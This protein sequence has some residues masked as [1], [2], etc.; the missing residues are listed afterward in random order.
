M[1]RKDYFSQQSSAYATFRPTYPDALYRFIFRHLKQKVCAWDCATGNGQVA[2]YLARHFQSVYATDISQQQINHASQTPNIVYS[3]SPAE[4]TVFDDRKFD[5]ITVAQALHWFDVSA[6]YQEVVRTGKPGGL[7][8]AWGYALLTVN[9]V[10]DELL[11]QFYHLKAGPFWDSARRLVENHYRDISFPFPAIDCPE[12]YIR[13]NWT[14]DQFS[15]YV[16][17]WSATQKYIHTHGADP[18]GEFRDSLRSVWKP[19]QVREVTFPVFMKLG[20]IG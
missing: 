8:A 3:V 12:F 7:I 18:V 15:G 17:S 1:E 9:P 16:T 13:A 19:G 5:L 6:F 11:L 10:V 2:R 14:L 4:K 20:R